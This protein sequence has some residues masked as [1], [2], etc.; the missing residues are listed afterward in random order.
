MLSLDENATMLSSFGLTHNQAKVYMAIAQLGLASVSQAS[1]ASKVRREDVYRILP[2]L[3]KM[4][5]VEKILGKPTQIRA[6]PMEEALHVLIEREQEIANKRVAGLKAKKDEILKHYKRFRMRPIS[7]G[8]H[9]SLISG[10]EGILGKEMAM[11]NKAESAISIITSRDKFRQFLNNYDE[12]LEKATNK[13]IEVRMILNATEHAAEIVSSLKKYENNLAPIYLKYTDHPMNHYMIVDFKK[14]LVATSVGP[15]MG[16]N[17]YLWT[18]DGSLVGLLQKNFEGLWHSSVDLETIE[19]E[20]VSEKMK[21]ILRDLDATNHIIFLYDSLEAKH[22]VLFSYLKFGL[23]KDEAGLYVTS[24]ENPSQIREAME[25]FGIHVEK[26]KKTGALNICGYEDIY[27]AD[28]KFDIA[29]TMNS[30]NKHYNRALKNG[31]KGIRVT[32]ETAWVFKRKL[33]QKFIE[34]EKSLHTVMD[35]PMIAICAYNANMVI[36]ASNPMD[37]YNELLKAHGKVLFSGL[38]KELGKIEIRTV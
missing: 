11:I 36:E 7:E 3:Q 37:L 20:A 23:E 29:A 13:G 8:A 6:I 27:L 10:R 17:P 35:I 30:W 19:T 4:G 38:D 15:T 24:E 9:F 12:A 25:K 14:A 33:I 21:R 5:L 32:G 18:D 1:K 34:Y 16:E 22:N 2:K 31:F 26:Y 28:G